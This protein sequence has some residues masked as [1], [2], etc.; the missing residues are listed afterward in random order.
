[1]KQAGELVSLEEGE[2]LGAPQF[3]ML[4]LGLDRQG[5]VETGSQDEL[6]CPGRRQ[7]RGQQWGELRGGAQGVPVKQ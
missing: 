5:K 6:E 4:Q 7:G 3:F 2:G 1:M